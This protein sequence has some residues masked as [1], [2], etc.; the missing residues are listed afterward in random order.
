MDYQVIY[1]RTPAGESAITQRTRIVQRNLRNVLDLV[2]GKRSVAE[3][4]KKFG[5][6][7]IAEAALADLERSGYIESEE[8]RQMRTASVPPATPAAAAASEQP[9]DRT[10]KSKTDDAG[11]FDDEDITIMDPLEF[12]EGGTAAKQAPQPSGK[13]F[14]FEDDDELTN[15]PVSRPP[16][17]S[18]K[19][20]FAEDEA[21]AAAA[22][23]GATATVRF[24]PL[25]PRRIPVL[26]WL[27]YALISLVTLL[28]LAA[29]TVLLFPYDIY[30]PR[31]ELRLRDTIGE[32]L[33]IGAMRIA[34]L[35]QPRLVFE[36]VTIGGE[37][38]FAVAR[39][40]VTPRLAWLVATPK[41]ADDVI[42][43]Q[44]DAD[45]ATLPRVADWLGERSNPY[46]VV[47]GLRFNQVKLRLGTTTVDGI[48]GEVV[49][50]EQGRFQ[51]L[52]FLNA[53]GNLGGDL[54]L[55]GNGYRIKI[56]ASEWRVPGYEWLQLIGFEGS[57]ALTPNALTLEKFDARSLDGVVSGKASLAWPNS[58]AEF[59]SVVE[60]KRLGLAKVLAAVRNDFRAE[61]DLSG[62][63]VIEARGKSFDQLSQA[64]GID[65]QITVQRGALTNM[66]FPEAVRSGGQSTTRGGQTRFEQATAN[67][68]V[69]RDV[70][71][72]S[73]LAFQSGLLRGDGYL[74]IG[75]EQVSG[76]VDVTFQGGSEAR[77]TVTVNGPLKDPSLNAIRH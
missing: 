54:K 42:F 10:V 38:A 1:F 8:G 17:P 15:L 37:G 46:F 5:D 40:G 12:P 35:P 71:Q 11:H 64:L 51:G 34:F 48:G 68:R 70:W 20:K 31:I 62:K 76:V 67:V 72:I 43:D 66:D 49:W 13:A 55:Q 63:L 3:I 32:P 36:D 14:P 30:L 4:V 27:K 57:G 45:I 21:P 56:S 7:S 41:I 52:R 77:A 16:P 59:A 58:G 19:P 73:G 50:D 2:D 39:I 6:A 25:P 61:G 18:R 9:A 22:D 53:S 23:A 29:G 28:V 75:P 69:N 33:R 74:N 44:V 60:I 26:K 47:R 65:G 24:E